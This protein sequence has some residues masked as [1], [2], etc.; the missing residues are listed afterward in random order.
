MNYCI[1]GVGIFIILTKFLDCWTTSR[2]ISHLTHESNPI[3][4][5][6]MKKLGIQQTIWLT[7]FITILIVSLSI[8]YLNYFCQDTSCSILFIM[9]GLIISF[10]HLAVAYT[11]TTKK[12]N[13]I[14][15]FLFYIFKKFP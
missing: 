13:P 6:L 11:N 3:A 15:A 12:I 14:T 4:R 5:R 10:I 8:G 7:F 1:F 9:V 2:N